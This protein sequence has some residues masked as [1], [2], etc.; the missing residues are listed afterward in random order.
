M[1]SDFLVG[2]TDWQSVL[3]GLGRTDWQSVLR[4]LGPGPGRAVLPQPLDAGPE[5]MARPP[6]GDGRGALDAGHPAGRLIGAC[7]LR[8][9]LGPHATAATDLHDRLDH[10]AD[11]V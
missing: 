6:A 3:R 7:G 2:R 4:G 8:P 5:V 10:V 9:V 1:G 11:R